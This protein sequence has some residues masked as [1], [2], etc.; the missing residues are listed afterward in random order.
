MPQTKKPPRLLTLLFAISRPL[1]QKILLIQRLLQRFRGLCSCFQRQAHPKP[2]ATGAFL[3]DSSIKMRTLRGAGFTLPSKLTLVR[4]ISLMRTTAPQI[5]CFAG[6]FPPFF[7]GGIGFQREKP[8][9]LSENCL[10]NGGLCRIREIM[11]TT[12]SPFKRSGNSRSS[13]CYRCHSSCK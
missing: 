12:E 13:R 7:L 5:A 10:R 1:M 4:I 11:R 3:E 6:Y 9:K 2:F 8:G